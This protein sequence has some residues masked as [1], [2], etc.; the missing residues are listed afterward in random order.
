MTTFEYHF[1]FNNNIC[2]ELCGKLKNSVLLP[3]P[4]KQ[5]GSLIK[6]QNIGTMIKMWTLKCNQIK[7]MPWAVSSSILPTDICIAD[8]INNL[9]YI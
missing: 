4:G 9:A 1:V 5:S 6:I 3:G 7:Q 8:G 2:H